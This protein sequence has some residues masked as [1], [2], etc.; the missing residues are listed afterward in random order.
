MCRALLSL[1][2]HRYHMIERAKRVGFF[3][4][5]VG[6]LGAGQYLEIIE[7]LKATASLFY[8]AV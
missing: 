5:L 7:R 4:I 2:L 8:L 3:G 1:H 6:T